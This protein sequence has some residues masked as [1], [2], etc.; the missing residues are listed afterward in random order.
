MKMKE[1]VSKKILLVLTGGLMV[2]GITSWASEIFSEMDK[3]NL[4]L[5]AIVWPDTNQVLIDNFKKIG[6]QCKTLPN[7]RK[8]VFL[9]MISFFRLLRDQRYDII[10]VCGSS[11]LMAIEL[12]ISRYLKIPVRICHSHNTMTQHPFLD[13]FL[14]PIMLMM[15]NT[16]LACGKDAGKWLYGNKEFIIIPNGKKIT[17]YEFDQVKRNTLRF[18]LGL[19]ENQIALVHIGRFNKQKN[20]VKLINIFSELKKRSDKYKLFLIGTGELVK[21]IKSLVIGRGMKDSVQFLGI[22]N[23][24]PDLLNAMDCLILPSLYEGFPN[25][26]VEGQINGLPCI[27]SKNITKECCLSELVSFCPI[28]ETDYYWADL[29]EK[30]LFKYER[31]Y[32]SKVSSQQIRKAGFDISDCALKLHNIYFK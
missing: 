27:L 16:Y 1:K 7:R 6:F 4:S 32:A 12:A 24:V 10:H 20:H 25:V 3:T 26:V 31:E 28:N 21:E 18:N 8:H 29:L 23:D 22:R 17:N 30:E 15:A 11:G 14:R 5:S 2:D 13:K 19:K 9:Y